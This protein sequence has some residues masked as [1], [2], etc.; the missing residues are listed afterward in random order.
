M[1][2]WEL[3]RIII[4]HRGG[5]WAVLPSRESGE[6][7]TSQNIIVERGEVFQRIHHGGDKVVIPLDLGENLKHTHNNAVI[8]LISYTDAGL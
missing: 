7:D 6:K 4:W 3:S 5:W 1:R 2:V 8:Y